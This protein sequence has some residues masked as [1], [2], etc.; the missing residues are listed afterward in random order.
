MR[1]YSIFELCKPLSP[2]CAQVARVNLQHNVTTGAVIIPFDVSIT[3]PP[4]DRIPG[5]FGVNQV[6]RVYLQPGESLTL[7]AELQPVPGGR[8]DVSGFGCTAALIGQSLPA[9]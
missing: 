6:V 9:S 2:P 3:L 8:S 1:F 7:M 5:K 4:A